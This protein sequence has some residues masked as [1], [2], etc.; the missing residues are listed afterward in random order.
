[1]T[2]EAPVKKK[3]G[4]KPKNKK[5][6]KSDVDTKT[7]EKKVKK[8][9]GR[10]PRGGKIVQLKDNNIN[11]SLNVQQNCILHLKCAT[12]EISTSNFCFPSTSN[13]QPFLLNNNKTKQ[14]QYNEINKKYHEKQQIS[15]DDEEVKQYE[16]NDVNLKEIWSK[17]RTLK[18]KLH[19]N[20]M[21]DKKSDCFHCTYSFSNPP[22]YIPKRIRNGIIEVYGCFCS[23]E[24]AVSH[25][26]CEPIDT[27]TKWERYSL[28]NNIYSKIYNY[29][30][31]IK[32]APNP[33]Y[34]LDKF[35]GNLSIQEYRKLLMNDRILLVVDKPLTKIMPELYEENNENPLI[36]ND[37]LSSEQRVDNNYRLQR[38]RKKESKKNILQ[39]KFNVQM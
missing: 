25:L 35:Y 1:M 7:E 13:I 4:R 23:P 2:I 24:C 22:I 8:K 10:K 28:L 11:D 3:R 18:Q 19:F 39:K 5:I 31:N 21:I 15:S 34:T 36:Y 17:L 38:K 20:D 6:A 33:Y 14:F 16:T 26:K 9:R 12:S 27:S 32:P 37:I 30:K 29:T